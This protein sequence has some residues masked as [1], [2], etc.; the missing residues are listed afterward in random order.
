LNRI[1]H[2]LFKTQGKAFTDVTLDIDNN[3]IFREEQ[4]LV[5]TDILIVGKNKA[6]SKKF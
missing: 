4:E 5:D 6:I 3:P 2:T 1:N